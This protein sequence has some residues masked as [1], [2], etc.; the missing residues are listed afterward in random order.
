M[1]KAFLST[2]RRLQNAK[3]SLLKMVNR[4]LDRLTAKLKRFFEDIIADSQI[5]TSEPAYKLPKLAGPVHNLGGG[6]PDV[7][8]AIQWMINQVRGGSNSNT[9]VNVLVIRAAGNDDYNQ[10]IYSMRGVKYVETLIIRNRQEANRTDIFDKVRNAGVIFFAGGDQCEYIRHWKNTKLEV[11]IKSVYDQGGAIGGTSAG[12]MIQSEYVYDSCACEDSI[13][14]HE[15]L[16]DP[17]GNITFT[18]NFFQWKYLRGTIIDT[19]FDERKRMGRIM[20]FIARQIQDGVSAKALGIAIS[21]QT[22]LLVDKYGI[23]KV[24]GKGSAYFVL[25]DHPPETCKKGTPLTYH[26]YKIWR[27]PR[28]D[29]FDLNKLPSKGYYLRS[30]KRGRFDS[31]PY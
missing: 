22:S 9:K 29:T 14:T 25:G 1:T 4:I 20:V 2:S 18:Y 5:P 16:D 19:H 28:G 21:E 13:E 30:V 3:N 15:A 31:D 12:A 24:T 27:V 10:L 11:A 8:D 6:G 7:D 23:A 17:Y 26:D